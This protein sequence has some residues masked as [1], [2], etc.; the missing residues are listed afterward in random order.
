MP[1]VGSSKH[2]F[3]S[4]GNHKEYNKQQSNRIRH[5]AT[6]KSFGF[7]H[8]TLTSRSQFLSQLFSLDISDLPFDFNLSISISQLI[9]SLNILPW[10]FGINHS[11]STYQPQFLYRLSVL[12]ILLYHSALTIQLNHLSSPI[13]SQ[14]LY[15]LF[16]FNISTR[17]FS[18]NNL[19]STSLPLFLRRLFSLDISAQL[20]GLNHLASTS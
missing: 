19:A 12:I 2:F 5:R 1:H 14:F 13:Q 16:S 4:H 17:P 10:A 3:Y 18:L 6:Y 20:F 15:Q 11:A 8:S 9:F 7:N